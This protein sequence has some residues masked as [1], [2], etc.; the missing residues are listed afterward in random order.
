MEGKRYEVQLPRGVDTGS[1]VRLSGKGPNGRDVVVTVRVRPHETY[2]RRGADLERELP[3]TL[4]EA[5]LGAEVP[6][7][8]S[9]DGS[10]S[11][12]LPGRRAGRTFR[13]TGQGMPKLKDGGTGDLYVKV[14]VVLPA[15]MSDGARDAATDVPGPR[16]PARSPVH[17][18]NPTS[19]RTGTARTRTMQLDRFTEKA[20]EAIVTA[21]QLAE[22][23]Q[24]PVLDAEHLLAALV[25]PD[26]GDP[27]RDAPAPRRGSR[28]RSGARSRP[29]WRGAPASRAASSAWIRAPGASSTAPRR[30][31]VGWA[32][33]TP[34]TEH[35][36]LGVAEVGGEAQQL[37]EK[38]GAGREAILGALQTVRGGQRVTSANPE[39]T[40]QAL[41]KY[42]RDLTAEARAGRLDPVIGRDEEIRR[43]IQVL[44][45]RTKN[46]PVLI[47]EPGVGKTA[48][49][50]GLAQR[51]VRGDVPETLKDKRVITLDLGA[52]IAGSK[53]RGEFEERLKAV[54]KEIKDS[55]GRVILFIDE[56]HTVV[57]AGAAEGAMDASNLLKPMLA[58]G[59]LH[60]IGATTLDEYRKHIEK[61]A[62]LER[63]FQPVVVDQPTVEETISILRGLRE[64]YE[65]HHGVRIT[66]SALVAAAT[67]SNRYITER[68]LPDKAIDLVD[69][70]ASRLRMEIDSMPVELDELERRRI[71]LEIER[72]A[73]RKES[74]EA[75]KARL[76][77]LEKELADVAEQAGAMKQRWEAEKAAIG[78]L[79]ETKSEIEQLAVRIEQAEREAD[80]GTAAELKYG[81]SR[82]L[83]DRM[84]AQEAAIAALQGPGA[85][86]KEEVSADDVAEIVA[87]WTG[88]PVT[89][90][91]EGELEKLVHMEERLHDRVVGPGRGDRR[92]LRCRPSRACRPQGP[93]AADRVVPVPGPHRRRQDGAGPGARPVPVRRRAG[94]GPHRHERVHGEVRGLAA[95]RGASRL[96]GLRGG[97]PADR[98]GP[99]AAVPGD[100]ARR[101]REGAPGRVQRAAPG[102]RR[103]PAHGLA[104]AGPWTSRTP[105]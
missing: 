55:E 21:Q 15:T 77:V 41:E 86:L 94:D 92:G 72:E 44:S 42:G 22:R 105:S 103:R 16:R 38:H 12:S 5:L 100:P 74:D 46:N 57:G 87:A 3:V 11:R 93:A 70:A 67:L 7:R 47:G 36:L 30:R 98:G 73:L 8:R 64:R 54:L 27:R 43:V 29:S 83:A 2:Q 20:Q 81:K 50:E 35:L 14:R 62:A 48:I 25:D 37:L 60:T 39:S 85:L 65:V 28:R 26:D 10:C 18:L 63:R 24:S 90:L 53:F 61:D 1:R 4:R 45:R 76:E 32:T 9:R 97:R 80:Y 89:R 91:M 78:A 23:M 59:E 95:G 51:I 40:Y 71:Q 13:L 102:A 79:R 52:L 101:D 88:I 33:S 31:R 66:D 104:R 34:R 6:V 17:H 75:S 58:R 69:E 84:A 99:A 49:A 68:F 56:L 19:H 96:R 82:E